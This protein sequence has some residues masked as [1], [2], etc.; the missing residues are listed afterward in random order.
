MLSV[1]F[2]SRPAVCLE[3][4]FVIHDATVERVVEE[5]VKIF[6]EMG[7]KVME[8]ESSGEAQA[9]ILAGKGALV[10]LTLKVLLFPLSLGEYIKSAQRSGIHIAIS[11]KQDGIHVYSCGIA[12]DEISGKLA[13]YT[14]DEIVE[15]VTDMMEAMDFEN[16]FVKKLS[17][18][19]PKVEE[20]K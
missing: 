2:L 18:A 10:P 14:K 17:T 9:T 8:K 1:C 12:L 15:E 13:Q 19:F 11:A 7:L 5:C 20:I 4:E 6:K 3:R 16:K